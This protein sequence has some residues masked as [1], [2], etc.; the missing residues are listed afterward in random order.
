[1]LGMPD[2]PAR[3][4]VPKLTMFLVASPARAAAMF[5]L[6]THRVGTAVKRAEIPAHRV[7]TRMIVEV[8]AVRN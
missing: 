5:P 7:G 1:M 8:E 3:K 6:P 2:R 4:R